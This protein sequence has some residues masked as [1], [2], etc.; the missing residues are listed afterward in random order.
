MT[1]DL[2]EVGGELLV[3]ARVKPRYRAGVSL[4]D[5]GLVV[6]VAAAPVQGKANEEARKVIAT[7]LRVSPSMVELR[8]GARSQ[9]KVFAVAG[10]DVETA[11][12]RLRSATASSPEGRPSRRRGS[13]R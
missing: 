7:V 10:L 5:Q 6:G 1:L 4:T 2:R 11:R 12:A 13:A 8:S 3:G 9:S